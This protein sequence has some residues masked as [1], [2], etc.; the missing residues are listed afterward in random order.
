MIRQLTSHQ[1]RRVSPIGR[2]FIVRRQSDPVGSS[3]LFLPRRGVG[4]G[5]LPRDDWTARGDRAGWKIKMAENV[6][7]IPQGGQ[8]HD[9][10]G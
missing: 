4:S 3:S 2:V 10:F 6:E 9:I 1:P 8:R 5:E 7:F